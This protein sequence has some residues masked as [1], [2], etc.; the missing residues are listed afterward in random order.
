MVHDSSL[1]TN[2]DKLIQKI[3]STAKSSL[4][5]ILADAMD[6]APPPP[7][8]FNLCKIRQNDEPAS[9]CFKNNNDD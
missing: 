5:Q 6:V 4:D 1:A 7:A 9:D 3:G 2:F 8:Q